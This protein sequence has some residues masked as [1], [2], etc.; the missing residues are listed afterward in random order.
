[1]QS[2]VEQALLRVLAGDGRARA[3][4]G[5]G[6]LVGPRHLITCAHVVNYALG[7]DRAWDQPEHPGENAIVRIDRPNLDPIGPN[8]PPPRDARVAAWYPPRSSAGPTEPNDVAVLELLHDPPLDLPTGIATEALDTAPVPTRGK[9]YGYPEDSGKGLIR[10]AELTGTNAGLI[11]ATPSA[12]QPIESGFSGGPLADEQGRILGMTALHNPKHQV[13]RVIPIE[14]LESAWPTLARLRHGAVPTIT[15]NLTMDG[16]DLVIQD[17][18][19]ERRVHVPD[20]QIGLAGGQPEALHTALFPDR[21]QRDAQLIP[22]PGDDAGPRALQLICADAQSAALPWH[23]LASDPG[24]PLAQ[25]GWTI[26][27]A[28]S[29]EPLRNPH[30]LAQALILAPATD[31]LA[32]GATVHIAAMEQALRDLLPDQRAAVDAAHDPDELRIALDRDP[33]LVYLYARIAS[34]GQLVL[35]QGGARPRGMP[36]ADLLDGLRHLGIRPIVWLHLIEDADPEPGDPLSVLDAAGDFPLVLLQRTGQW[37]VTAGQERALELVRHLAGSDRPSPAAA[38]GT[39]SQASFLALQARCGLVLTSP[40]APEAQLKAQI[41]AALIRLRLGRKQQRN[42]IAQETQQALDGDMLM[43][44]VGG[45]RDA[46]PAELPDQI[47]YD[48]ENTGDQR[49]PVRVVRLML[50]LDL[51]AELAAPGAE[52]VLE[53]AIHTCLQRD[54]RLGALS[55]K[56]ALMQGEPPAAPDEQLILLLSWRLT[57]P[58]ALD[59]PALER[60][61]AAWSR[62]HASVFPPDQIPER[63]RLLVG[64]CVQWPAGWCQDAGAEPREMADGLSRALWDIGQRGIRTIEYLDP[65]DLLSE[66]DLLTFFREIDKIEDSCTRGH[67]PRGLAAWA[68]KEAGGRFDDTVTLIYRACRSRFDQVPGTRPPGVNPRASTQ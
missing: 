49:Y 56:A 10:D 12:G 20:L 50:S 68:R 39:L 58:A 54:L 15:L 48:L 51:D 21:S 52:G 32:P 24:K 26:E 40:R 62:V 57:V 65:L 38:L 5:A 9:A 43:F 53:S 28:R 13:A 23:C 31:E 59:A 37:G 14:T 61:V 55:P 42:Q 17:T 2:P 41:R 46:R 33:E 47:R 4:V 36:V 25:Q 18:R 19:G 3:W 8:G 1:M 11:Q 6:W 29:G 30:N 66:R 67:D 45:Q 64:A 35:G 27:C 16:D 7:G 44:A 34:D 60:W 22:A 63:G